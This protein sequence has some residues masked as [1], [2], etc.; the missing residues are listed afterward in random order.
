[1]IDPIALARELIDV[2]STTDNE[3]AVAQLLDRELTRLGYTV[4]RQDATGGRFN[5]FAS[6]GGT[7]RVVINSHIDTVPPWFASREDDDFVYG[8]GA[9]DTKGI[10]AAMI[11][12]GE[13]RKSVV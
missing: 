9:C 8:R 1:M 4:R 2:P 7:P 6:M 10:I 11:A 3:R 13:D 5:V 12:A